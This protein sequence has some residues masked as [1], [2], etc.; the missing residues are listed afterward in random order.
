[1]FTGTLLLALFQ[2]ILAARKRQSDAAYNAGLPIG[3]RVALVNLNMQRALEAD[4]DFHHG[5]CFRCHLPSLTYHRAHTDLNGLHGTVLEY[6]V[7]CSRFRVK[8]LDRPGDFLGKPQV[9][10]ASCF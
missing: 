4:F 10:C 8:L 3:S 6:D 1:M 2:A 7:G 9:C 5:C